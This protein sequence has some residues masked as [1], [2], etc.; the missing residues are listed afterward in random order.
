MLNVL[1]DH[2]QQTLLESLNPIL[3]VLR[4][5]PGGRGRVIDARPICRPIVEKRAL[6]DKPI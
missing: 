3:N 1:A 2:D 4:S 5:L 6:G